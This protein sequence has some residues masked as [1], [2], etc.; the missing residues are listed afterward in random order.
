MELMEKI[1]EKGVVISEYPP[2][3]RPNPRNFPRRNLIISAWSHKILVIEAG[4]KSGSLITADYG[5]KHGREVLALP[6]NIYRQESI[7]SNK[8]IYKGAIPYLNQEQLLIKDRYESEKTGVNISPALN[9]LDNLKGM[10]KE[11]I[12]IL[13]TQSEKTLE[14]LAIILN[15]NS[16]ELI[17]E[18]ALMELEGKVRIQGSRVM[19]GFK[20]LY[21]P[22]F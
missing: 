9:E 6:D 2:G 13:L 3:T 16:M 14:E 5:I 8:L 20:Y 10:E 17:G 18:L 12:D 7:G 1:I 21:S 11:I 19:L 15:I 4:E 22:S